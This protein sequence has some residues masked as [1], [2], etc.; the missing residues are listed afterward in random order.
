M[1][2]QRCG[3]ASPNNAE[4]CRA[5]GYRLLALLPSEAEEVLDARDLLASDDASAARLQTIEKQVRRASEEVEI[6]VHALEY[7]ERSV[8]ADRAGIHALVRMLREK[9]HLDA[10]EFQRRWLERAARN[11]GELALKDRFMERKDEFL[12]AFRGK[13]PH[14]FEEHLDRAEDLFFLLDSHGALATL[15]E[16]CTLDP[17]NLSLAAFLGECLLEKGEAARSRRYL[18]PAARA[19]DPPQRAPSAWARLLLREGDAAG[20]AAY[21]EGRLKRSP[22]D[23]DLLVH[24]ALARG[25][26]GDWGPCAEAAQRALAAQETPAAYFLLAH[27]LLRQEKVAPA[28]A[29]LNRLVNLDSTCEEALLQQALLHMDRGRWNRARAV[30]DR[31]HTLDPDRDPGEI[32]ERFRKA[33]GRRRHISRVLPLRLD[34]IFDIMGSARI[35]ARMLLRQAESEIR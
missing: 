35:E 16:A 7:L 4:T 3:K 14:R 18:E 32:L 31:L 2:C 10:G 23:A 26:A 21:V 5:C 34:S 8:T 13:N 6:L 24:L 25:L 11:L 9:G 33:D 12:G 17:D 28:E 1:L 22:R 20:A 19:K 15:E 29:A 27:A 30:L